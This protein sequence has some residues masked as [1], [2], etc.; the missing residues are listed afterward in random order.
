MMPVRTGVELRHQF[1]VGCPGRGE[2]IAA[3]L[4]LA[5]QREKLLFVP[6]Q[7]LLKAADVVGC[8]KVTVAEDGLTEV[9][10]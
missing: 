2:F 4:E 9:L 10:G 8:S 5:A 6:S 3:F 1:A 7:C